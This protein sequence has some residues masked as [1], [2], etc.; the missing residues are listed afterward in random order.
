[1][2]IPGT[3]PLHFPVPLT[4]ISRPGGSSVNQTLD[5][6]RGQLDGV[7]W[8]SAS[9]GTGGTPQKIVNFSEDYITIGSDR[10]RVFHTQVHI[11]EYH[12]ICV[13]EDV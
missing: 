10:Y 7:Y 4:I 9:T 2:P 13:K 1:M 6:V 11:R 12:Y 3:T 5:S 8:I